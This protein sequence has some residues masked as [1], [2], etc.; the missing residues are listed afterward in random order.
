M[1][2]PAVSPPVTKRLYCNRCQGETNHILH[3]EHSCHEEI[4][5]GHNWETTTYRLWTCAGCDTATMETESTASYFFDGDEQQ[6]SR[7]Y[8]PPRSMDDLKPKVFRKI[9]PKL[10]A[11]YTQTIKA[12]NHQLRVLCAAGL[13]A[14]IEGI[15]ADKQVAGRTLEK[16]IDALEAHLPKTIVANLHGF[17]FMGNEALHELTA[18]KRDE[19]KIAIEVSEDLLNLLYELDYKAS[20]LPKKVSGSQTS[21]V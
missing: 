13:R 15:C 19:L 6:Y 5:E 7:S 3:G 11:I 20:L 2:Q 16:K 8:D 18:P 12:F 14:L 9:P 10:R 4:D 17:R 21:G 1:E